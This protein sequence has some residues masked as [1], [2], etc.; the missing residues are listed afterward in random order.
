MSAFPFS[1]ALVT[2]ASSGIG[3]ELARQLGAGGVHVALVARRQAELESLAEEVTRSGGKAI[4]LPADL[5]RPEQALQVVA[6]TEESLGRLDLVIANAGIGSEGPVHEVAW[7]RIYDTIMV[8]TLAPMVAIRAALPGMLQRKFGYVAGI[9]SLASYRGLPG[10]GAYSSSK[11]ALST[12]L[13]SLRV[14]TRGLGISVTDIHPGFVRTEMTA[15]HKVKLPFLMEVDRAAH[16]ILRAIVRKRPIYNF[17]WQ[18]A[19]LLRIA[20][21]LPPSIYDRVVTARNDQ[22]RIP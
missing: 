7:E 12:F 22:N 19:L 15:K 17:P 13:E 16:L 2:G 6:E 4:V 9:S 8:N 1:T 5:R 21:M 10:S 20:R 14:D 11:A 3:R 18:M